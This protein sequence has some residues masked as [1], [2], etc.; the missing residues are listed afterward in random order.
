MRPP[1]VVMDEPAD[2]RL[3]AVGD[4]ATVGLDVEVVGVDRWRAGKLQQQLAH[5]VV[6]RAADWTCSCCC[7]GSGRGL[8]PDRDGMPEQRLF[9]R[10][11]PGEGGPNGIVDPVLSDIRT[12]A[13]G[14]RQDRKA[15]AAAT[16]QRLFFIMRPRRP[17]A[18]RPRETARQA[19]IQATLTTSEVQTWS[20]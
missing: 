14:E 3:R 7:A 11:Q 8:W 15:A 10:V 4:V 12:S 18:R 1:G 9:V 5:P 19:A 6:A 2:Q 20:V 16:A 13:A 17:G